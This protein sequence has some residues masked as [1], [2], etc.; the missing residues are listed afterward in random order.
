MEPAEDCGCVA[1][2]GVRVSVLKHIILTYRYAVYFFVC[3]YI[4]IY[5]SINMYVCA[6]YNIYTYICHMYKLGY[7]CVC[8]IFYSLEEVKGSSTEF[9]ILR[10][11]QEQ[12][13]FS[14]PL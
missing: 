11:I 1:G 12:E 9:G 5:N 4:Y 14:M 6:L 13:G 8:I 7:V 10:S 2:V 3:V